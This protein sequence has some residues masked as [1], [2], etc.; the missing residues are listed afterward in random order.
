MDVGILCIF[1]QIVVESGGIL[2]EMLFSEVRSMDDRKDPF[3][4]GETVAS[5][6][7]CTGLMP[8]LPADGQQDA[9]YAALYAIHSAKR[10]DRR[11]RLKE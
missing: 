9:N 10:R 7:E 6:T 3:Y 5:L 2:R 1:R 4:D 8:A 11:R